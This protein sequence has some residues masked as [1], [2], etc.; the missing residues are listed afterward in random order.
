MAIPTIVSSGLLGR[1]GLLNTSPGYLTAPCVLKSECGA[2][3]GHTSLAAAEACPLLPTTFVFLDDNSYRRVQFLKL[4][5]RR[6]Q[7]RRRRRV[8]QVLLATFFFLLLHILLL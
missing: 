2:L 4:C 3:P 5:S 1:L 8:D 7:L 6:V